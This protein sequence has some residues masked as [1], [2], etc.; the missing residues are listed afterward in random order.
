MGSAY[1][2]RRKLSSG[3]VRYQVRYRLGGRAHRSRHAGS[4]PTR[5]DARTRRDLV[6]GRDPR[7]DLERLHGQAGNTRTL[8]QWTESY[9]ES[10]RDWAEATQASARFCLNKV[11]ETL[12]HRDP[13]TLTPHD[14]QHLVGQLTE[15]LKPATVSRYL[16][17]LRPLLDYTGVDPNPARDR[18][19]KLPPATREELKPPTASEFLTILHNTPPRLRLPLI[20][21]EQTGIRVGELTSL[22][23]GNIDTENQRIR[24][25]S[26]HAKT[27]RPRW[28]NIPE[29]LLHEIETTRP[30]EG[31]IE[32]RGVFPGLTPD[33]I[34]RAMRNACQ[35]AGTPHYHPHDLRHRRI[36]L[37]HNQNVPAAE[38]A[39][40]AGHA[41]PSITLDTYSHVIPPQETPQNQL[42]HA[43][44]PHLV[45]PR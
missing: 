36:S 38:L 10:R 9:L 4:F 11:N 30:T 41:R 7:R 5:K 32:G 44:G 43:L 29:W 27:R 33:A 6:A 37:W 26:Q 39:Q 8:S 17:M 31:R 19:V 24:I 40:R 21:L 25:T 3:G 20:V 14:I 45:V 23:W 34:R 13:Q 12:G 16:A 42:K 28:V 22:T 2:A 35:H 18:T 1:I 15:N